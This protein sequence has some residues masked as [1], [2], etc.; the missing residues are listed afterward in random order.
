MEADIHLYVIEGDGIDKE[1]GEDD[2]EVI[3]SNAE[4]MA[5]IF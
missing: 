1:S 3:I 5:V 2:D 4:V